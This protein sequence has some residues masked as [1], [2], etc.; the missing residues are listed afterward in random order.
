M[1]IR[2]VMKSE[3]RSYHSE[4]LLFE[5]GHREFKHKILEDYGTD[6]T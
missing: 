1:V 6:M 4:H 2:D 3:G 5:F